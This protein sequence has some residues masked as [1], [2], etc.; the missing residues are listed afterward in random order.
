[1]KKALLEFSPE[2]LRQALIGLG[3]SAFRAKQ[4]YRWLTACV[5]FAEMRNLPASLRTK[6]AGIYTEGYP[7]VEARLASKDGTLKYLLRLG[8][9]NVIEAVLMRYRY[10]HTLCI[11]TQ[12]GCPMACTFCAS[13]LGGLVRN[14]TRG[15]LL[16]Q[17]LRVNAEQGAGRNI[18]NIVLMGTGEPLLNYENVVSFLRQIHAAQSLGIA[19][20][21]ISLSTCGIVPG[22]DALAEEGLPVTLC[23][24][25]HSA[26]EEK[27]RL[28][29]PVENTYPLHEA[30][31][32]MRRYSEKTGRRIIYE[33]ILI[34]GFN[35]SGEDI[36]ALVR[37]TRGQRCHV[38]LIP[39][40]AALGSY[41]TPGKKQIYEFAAEL[42]KK[43]VSA[44]VRRTLG[45][46][47][48]GACGQLRAHFAG[49]LRE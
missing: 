37:L 34:E 36:D 30:V 9:G 38:N 20:R 11:S 28:L 33:Y 19:L 5:P 16:G 22:I 24:S 15:E 26:I 44:S 7:A 3:E 32:A 39:L 21:N 45:E 29:M 41:K 4:V 31:A 25:L 6:L 13:G 47:I 10:G 8:D 46:D 17:V 27:R 35:M 23:L 49:K 12:V 43:G 42:E 14:L 2:E 1:M 40:N 48:E 18:T